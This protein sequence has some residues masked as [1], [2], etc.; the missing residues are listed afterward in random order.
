MKELEAKLV[1]CMGG[2]AAEERIY[3]KDNTTSGAS[4]DL[5]QATRIARAMV[6]KCVDNLLAPFV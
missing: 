6:M 5:Q 2:R 1:V 3:G 4:S